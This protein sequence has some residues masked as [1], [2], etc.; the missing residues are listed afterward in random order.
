VDV[1]EII[2]IDMQLAKMILLLVIFIAA[3][4]YS[5]AT[6]STQLQ[7]LPF[8]NDMIAKQY[9][10]G[11][12][13]QGKRWKDNTGEN[14]VILTV[15][16]VTYDVAKPG[17]MGDEEGRTELLA[18][19]Y[20]MGAAPQLLWKTNDAVGWCG[21]DVVAEFC[22]NSLSVTDLDKDGLAETSFLYLLACKGDVSPSTK[23]L[24]MH[25]GVAKYAIRGSETL[26]FKG[27]K[28]GGD[29]TPDKAFSEAPASFLKY[30]LKQWA[31]YGITKMQ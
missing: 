7:I 30:A 2:F 27:R 26:V 11:K 5:Q 12:I 20:R 1:R 9:Y 6:D 10:T 15:N 18:W 28:E 3:A 25:E 31:V 4:K 17:D 23:K 16:E 24:I 8:K 22:K 19:H 13:V 29:K 14:I 21:L